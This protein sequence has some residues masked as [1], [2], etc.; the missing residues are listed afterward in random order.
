MWDEIERNLSPAQ[1]DAQSRL[2]IIHGNI[3]PNLTVMENF[4]TST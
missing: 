1:L 2:S 4:K 3:F